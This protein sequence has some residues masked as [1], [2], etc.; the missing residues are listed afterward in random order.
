MSESGGPD[1]IG[2]VLGGRYRLVALIGIGSSGEVYLADDTQ[3]RRQVAVKVLHRH[4]ADDE[5][6]LR[7][8]RAEAQ[9]AAGL[10]HQHIVSVFDWGEDEVP[11]IVTEYLSGGSLRSMLDAKGT[12]TPSQAL[13]IGLEASRGLDFAHRRGVVQRDIKP[14]N[15]LFDG[16][17]H[18]RI[19]DFGLAKALAEASATE[20]SGQLVGTV[21]YA[22]PEQAQGKRVEPA[23]DVYSLGLVLIEAVTGELPFDADTPIATLMA[24][25]D[26]E[27]ALD[28]ALGALRGPV[29]RACAVDPAQRP[30]A[31][32][33]SV[34]LMAAAENMPRPEPLPLVGAIAFD[35]IA[36]SN[37]DQTMLVG[38]TDAPEVAEPDVEDRRR[39]RRRDPEPATT[40]RAGDDRRRRRWPL[41]LLALVV[42]AGAGVGTWLAL[43]STEV[44]T[45]LVPDA[46]GLTPAEFRTQ[47]GDFW[48]LDEALVRLDDS[49]PGTIVSTDPP[50]GTELEQ[51]AVIEYFVSQGNELRPVPT[52]L[53]GLTL[54]EAEAFLMGAGLELGATEERFD[55][56]ALPG[57]VV[58]VAT[59]DTELPTGEAVDLVVSRGPRPRQIP[60]TLIGLT[61]EEA[62][63]QL[64]SQSLQANRLEAFDNAVPA[65]IVIAVSPNPGRR[66]PR[67]SAVDLTVSLGPEPVVIPDVI[68]LDVPSAAAALRNAGLTIGD[69][70]GPPDTSV[71][72]TDPAAGT[73][74][75]FGFP[76]RIVTSEFG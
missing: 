56:Q 1:H 75:D 10:T 9:V 70:D 29:G 34:A 21:R 59:A 12:I 44:A 19:A 14:A 15:I 36:A 37:R 28:G 4:L 53:V 16:D 63:A 54:E 8:F 35:P 51:D 45:D 48:V 20:P 23:S 71:I 5:V 18:V 57:V 17:G 52:N 74:V 46:V 6:F 3:L 30:A 49:V 13:L 25:V 76:V 58:E 65:G 69:T 43:D 60:E 64:A 22:S 41:V 11:Y 42:L 24:R 50:A 40:G 27:V 67:D 72:A 32:E 31:G 62:Q 68:G 33:L 38:A 7:R 73:T 61:F 66:V 26:T 47:V 55:E 2:R 39:R